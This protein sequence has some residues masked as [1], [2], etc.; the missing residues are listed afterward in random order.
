M[1]RNITTTTHSSTIEENLPFLSSTQSTTSEG[2]NDNNNEKKNNA[3]RLLY[4]PLSIDDNNNENDDVTTTTHPKGVIQNFTSMCIL[5]SIH[6]GCVVA[7]LS[8]ATARLGSLGAWQSGI[9]YTS[10]TLSA[11]MGTT[12]IVKKLGSR[13]SLVL[14]MALYC[15]YVAC[16]IV[17]INISCTIPSSSD[18]DNNNESNIMNEDEEP[19]ESATTTTTRKQIAA[20]TGAVIGGIGA[21][22]LWTA[23]GAFAVQAAVEHTRTTATGGGE[24]ALSSSSSSPSVLPSSSSTSLLAGIFAFWY[25]VGEVA[26]R[27]LASVLLE[28]NVTSWYGIFSIYTTIAILSTIGMKICVYKYPTSSSASSFSI[29]KS[30]DDDDDNNDDD[31]DDNND[32]D[33]KY[34]TTTSSLLYKVTAAL[35]LLMKDPKMKHM[36]GL[37]AV[38]GFTS[39]FVSSYVNGEVIPVVLHDPDTKYV[40]LFTSWSSAVA[41]IMS[42]VFGVNQQQKQPKSSSTITTRENDNKGRILILGAIFFMGVA[43]PFIIVPDISNQDYWD[44]K[45]LTF[46]YTFQ[47]IGRATFEGPLKAQFA[48]FFSYESEGAFANIIV[49]SGFSSGVGLIR[50][51]LCSAHAFIM[52]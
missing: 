9:L 42:I 3:K 49:Q 2:D 35:Q 13:D 46:I 1:T 38:F 51:C 31:D 19:S 7:C 50:E 12:Y 16:F 25:L 33:D 52:H 36:I 40:G 20:Y 27:L 10:Y 30:S 39:A 17:A 28:F 4:V 6:H 48:D 5:F 34:R 44:W 45:L 22:C 41:V 26:L 43:I 21:G 32:N 18:D 23:Q 24:V 14:G 29:A 11:L 15:A 47:G 37:N 8:L